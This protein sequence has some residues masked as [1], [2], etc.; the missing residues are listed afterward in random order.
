[1]AVGETGVTDHNGRLQESVEPQLWQYNRSWHESNVDTLRIFP[2]AHSDQR[3]YLAR[4]TNPGLTVR[5]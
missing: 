3:P 2:I 4:W 5:T 1:M